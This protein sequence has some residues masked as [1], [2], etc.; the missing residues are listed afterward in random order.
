MSDP[1]MFEEM[2]PSPVLRST[3]NLMRL[4]LVEVQVVLAFSLASGK[5]SQKPED[6]C[7]LP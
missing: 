4:L 3:A 7:G 2:T 1:G 5:V 6:G